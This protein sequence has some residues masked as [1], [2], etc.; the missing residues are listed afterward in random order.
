MIGVLRTLGI[1][2]VLALILALV[3]IGTT[4]DTLDELDKLASFGALLVAVLAFVTTRG[5]SAGE[6]V[7]GPRGTGLSRSRRDYLRWV[8]A[9]NHDTDIRGT[10]IQGPYSLA[11]ESVFVDVGLIPRPVHDPTGNPLEQVPGEPI[12]GAA[13]RQ[14]IWDFLRKQEMRPLVVLGPPGS[15]KSTLLKHVALA[16]A[17]GRAKD[18]RGRVPILLTI[19]DHAAAI[20]EDGTLPLVDVVTGSLPAKLRPVYSWLERQLDRG[21]CIVMLD[22]LDEVP[23]S[24]RPAVADWV[25]RQIAALQGSGFLLTSRPYGYQ[26]T[27]LASADVVQVRPFTGQQIEDFLRRWYQATEIRR[28]GRQDDGVLA[29]ARNRADDLVERLANAPNLRDLAI[30][31]LLLTMMAH[32]HAYRGVLP[33]SRVDLY[34]AI[35]QAFLG[36]R[37]EV[38]GISSSLTT[39][40]RESVLKVLAL[41][42]MEKRLRDMPTVEAAAAISA[43]LRRVA[44]QITPLAFLKETEEQSGLLLEREGGVLTFAHLTFQ[45]YLAAV[46]VHDRGRPEWLGEHTDDSWWRETTILYCAQ[47]DAGPVIEACLDQGTAR[48]LELALDCL[49]TARELDP[50]LRA[51]AEALLAAEAE[52]HQGSLGKALLLR[53]LRRVREAGDGITL[54]SEPTSNAEYRAFLRE[55]A[56]D[57]DLQPLHWPYATVTA[58]APVVAVPLPACPLFSAWLTAQQSTRFRYEID[59]TGTDRSAERALQNWQDR[60]LTPMIPPSYRSGEVRGRRASSDLSNSGVTIDDGQQLRDAMIAGFREG[61]FR[62]LKLWTL[63]WD[64]PNTGAG[65]LI[66]PVSM[67]RGMVADNLSGGIGKPSVGDLQRAL[68]RATELA[69]PAAG[70]ATTHLLNA[71]AGWMS[72]LSGSAGPHAVIQQLVENLFAL[73]LE[74]SREG[75]AGLAEVVY[76][77]LDWAVTLH[78]RMYGLAPGP[79]LW[80]R[81]YEITTPAA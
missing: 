34:R 16:L 70:A 67:V 9:S 33:G 39:D 25:A 15:G 74:A 69:R 73:V 10:L 21:R 48:S 30:N 31:P 65:N 11:V 24:L 32:V 81:R 58:D 53:K 40:Q 37:Q 19:R 17:R 59:R 72:W 6:A 23:D 62:P 50:A 75:D 41:V 51:R 35:C 52:T 61:N 13:G 66:G 4:D 36:G 45:E 22:G 26:S 63:R 38:K 18:L 71:R 79:E 60:L 55:H 12:A 57:P 56:D 1:T 49:D 54:V 43:T 47:A 76:P 78:W 14:S 27:P 44:P 7:G 77:M 20:G 3:F 46:E 5:Q 29:E 68:A 42:M 2:G 28:T 8:I 64:F 80:I